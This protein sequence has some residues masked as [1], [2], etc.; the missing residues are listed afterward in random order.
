MSE[1]AEIIVQYVSIWAP[2]LVAILGVVATIIGALKKVNGAVSTIKTH[3]TIK[4]LGDE[5]RRLTQENEELLKCYKLLL[6]NITR[7][8]D[9]TDHKGV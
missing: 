9:Y 8:K 2:S 3:T 1:I 6:D 5:V 4:D 7:I